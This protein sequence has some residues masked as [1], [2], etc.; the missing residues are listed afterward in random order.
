ML[1]NQTDVIA[2]QLQ[3]IAYPYINAITETGVPITITT[4]QNSAMTP[5]FGRA[6]ALS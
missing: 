1:I 2:T 4:N 6:S 5:P 3:Q